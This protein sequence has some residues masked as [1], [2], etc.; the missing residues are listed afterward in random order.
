MWSH[1]SVESGIFSQRVHDRIAPRLH[2]AKSNLTS[3]IEAQLALFLNRVFSSVYLLP[4]PAPDMNQ[5]GFF[6]NHD[7]DVILV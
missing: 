6:A 1:V 4:G 2:A 3:A 7:D 5:F